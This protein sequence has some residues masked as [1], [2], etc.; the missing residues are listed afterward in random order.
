MTTPVLVQGDTRPTLIAYLHDADDPTGYIDLTDA[1]V[2]FQMRK[3][4]DKVYTVNA[5]A[6][7]L[8]LPTAKVS[9]TLGVNDLNVPGDYVV[10]W[11]VTY[12]DGGKQTTATPLK[13]TVRRQ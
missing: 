11:E 6:T 9:Y 8:D 5:A 3:A 1:T 13:V 4:D 12:V 2:L 7:I 10:Q